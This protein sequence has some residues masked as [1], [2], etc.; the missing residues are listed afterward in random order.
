MALVH[1][2]TPSPRS[3]G[4]N[5]PDPSGGPQFGRRKDCCVENLM[6]RLDVQRIRHGD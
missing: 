5:R 3:M 4:P 1:F 2:M 6:V